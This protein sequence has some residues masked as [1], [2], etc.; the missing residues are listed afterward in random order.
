MNI[1]GNNCIPSAIYKIKGEI[2][3][4]PFFWCAIPV[5]QYIWM[6][7][8]FKKIDWTKITFSLEQYYEDKSIYSVLGK[9]GEIELHFLHYR[10]SDGPT[11]TVGRNTF[12]KDIIKYAKDKWF[13]RLKLLDR[14]GL[15]FFF[16]FK[17]IDKDSPQYEE[18]I[19][20]FLSMTHRSLILLV[21]ND[22][23]INKPIPKNVQVIYYDLDKVENVFTVAENIKNIVK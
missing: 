16:S 4:H 1:I 11:K 22:K 7:E 10:L 19:D 12:S 6:I 18:V 17:V 20:K 2:Y 3:N 5:D 9:V 21:H 23:K 14:T 8:N 15:K 13:K